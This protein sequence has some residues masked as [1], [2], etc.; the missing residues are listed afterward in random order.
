MKEAILTRFEVNAETYHLRFHSTRRRSEE[1]YKMLLSRQLDQLNYWTQ[2][3][4]SELKQNILL[5]QFLQSL[6][7]DLAVKLRETKPTSAKEAASWADDYD[8]AHRGQESGKAA[9]STSTE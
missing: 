3:S 7:T 4:G 5:E 1:S 8:Q 2:S 6:P 9:S